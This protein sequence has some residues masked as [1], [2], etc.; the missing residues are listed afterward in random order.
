MGKTKTKN[1]YKSTNLIASCKVKIRFSEVDSMGVVWH[2][3]YVRL[4]EDGREAFGSKYNLTYLDY[5]YNEVYTPIVNVNCDYKKPLRYGD[6]AIIE[7]K[8]MACDAAKIH[9]EYTIRNFETNEIVATGTTT[10]VFIDQEHNLI[11]ISPEFYD[12]WKKK[13]LTS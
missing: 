9:F 11:L 8:Y 10:Q 4:F 5:Y 7:A 13:W 6:T 3:N 12:E 1:S 2:G